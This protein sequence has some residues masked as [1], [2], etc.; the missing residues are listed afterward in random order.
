MIILALP[1][2]SMILVRSAYFTCIRY[3]LLIVL[4]ISEKAVSL[5]EISRDLRQG[6]QLEFLVDPEH[7]KKFL[8][9]IGVDDET[10]KNKEDEDNFKQVLLKI[11][12]KEV[13]KCDIYD[14]L[15]SVGLSD[16]AEEWRK[17]Y[18][19]PSQYALYM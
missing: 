15:K 6:G 10:V 9:A 1:K 14:T 17:K 16:F 4:H 13:S 12:E 18:M 5:D 2:C 7:R 8:G 3:S 11:T 19:H